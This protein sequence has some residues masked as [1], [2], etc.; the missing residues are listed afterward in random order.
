[1]IISV[2]N[3]LIRVGAD[4]AFEVFDARARTIVPLRKSN[5]FYTAAY[6]SDGICH[7]RGVMRT[8]KGK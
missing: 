6:P 1:M 2:L 3:P 5:N 4:E 8:P 7:D